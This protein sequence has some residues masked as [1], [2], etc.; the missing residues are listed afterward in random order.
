MT[1]PSSR[2][3]TIAQRLAACLHAFLAGTLSEKLLVD[4]LRAL[5][6]KIEGNGFEAPKRDTEQPFVKA[7][8]EHW[9]Q[10][11][12]K[13]KARLTPG[14]ERAIRARLVHYTNAV[15]MRAIDACAASDFHM[16]KNDS[17]TPYNDLTLILRSDEK[18]DQFLAMGVEQDPEQNDTPEVRRL[19]QEAADAMERGDTLAYN[20]A[21][22]CLSAELNA[23]AGQAEP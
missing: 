9:R 16:G 23:Q 4:R 8:F 18:L 12:E 17:N 19:Q 10:R 21:N 20:R 13:P 22:T 1:Y 2:A 5:A 7:V 3:R 14:R 15:L 11:M 6:S